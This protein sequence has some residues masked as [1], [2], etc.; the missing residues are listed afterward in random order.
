MDGDVL[1]AH[2]PLETN[3]L[4]HPFVLSLLTTRD[5]LILVC[6]YAHWL[7][8]PARPLPLGPVS[9]SLKWG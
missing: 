9:S 3:L 5:Q 1:P 6:R 7:K 4:S 2:P 8:I